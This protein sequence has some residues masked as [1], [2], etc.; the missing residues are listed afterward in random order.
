MLIWY[1]GMV[2]LVVPMVANGSIRAS[3]D[4]KFPALIIMGS[5]LSNIALDPILIFGWFG[6]PRLEVQGAAL[7]TI[8]SRAGTMV[9]ALVLIHYRDRM[10]DFSLPNPRAVWQSWKTIA[11][12][13]LPATVTNIMGPA[14]LGVVTRLI[15]AF[16]AEAVAAWGA[17]MRVSF[18]A[19]IPTFAVCSA[20][21]PLIGQNWG[22]ELYPRV[23]QT[24]LYA[25]RFALLWGLLANAA[26]YL[27]AAPIA[28][29][30]SE[31]PAVVNQIQHYLHIV[32]FGYALVGVFQV[33]EDVLNTIGRPFVS[34]FQTFIYMFLFYIPLGYLGGIQ[35]DF[36]GLLWGLVAADVLA[37]ILGLTLMWRLCRPPAEAQP[38]KFD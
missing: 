28:R 27:G 38:K 8:I 32:P 1:P 21:V 33:A 3:G 18:F 25:Y 13:A 10:I 37:G 15:A 35:G 17:G 2:F 26:L 7:A 12:I 20:L 36:T 6:L 22:A 30:F 16:G 11:Q 24:R 5:T 23:H 31:D 34:A 29:L 4:A 19:L 9:A 14:A